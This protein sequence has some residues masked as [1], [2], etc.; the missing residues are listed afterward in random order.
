MR[1]ALEDYSDGF[2]IGGRTV[3]N[4]RYADDTTLIATSKESLLE[5][6]GL[7]K[8][9]SERRGLFLNVKKTKVM[10]IDRTWNNFD[11]FVVNQDTIE[12]FKQFDFPGSTIDTTG[13]SSVEI[14]KRLAIART[15]MFK[16]DKI[17]KSRIRLALELRLLKVTVFSIA[18]YG[19]ESWA[20]SKN[21]ENRVDAFEL[22]CYRRILG[23]SWQDHITN[24]HVLDRMGLSQGP[25]LRASIATTKMRYLGHMLR[26]ESLEKVIAIG[27][28][29]GKRRQGR[30][31]LNWTSDFTKWIGKKMNQKISLGRMV[32]LA[33]GR[34][35]WRELSDI[36]PAFLG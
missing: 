1:D 34:K 5:L 31:Q 26:H 14:K 6:I 17:W 7:V 30:P 27:Q 28:V 23:I 36:T 10:V 32:R 13:Q 19:A 18:R 22:W 15:T 4:L 11:P 24:Q 21:D 25:T 8:D 3:Q 33:E 12:E 35:K 20:M 16:L 9:A 29:R 2:R